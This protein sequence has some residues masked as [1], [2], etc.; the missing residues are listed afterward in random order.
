MQIGSI[1]FH[2]Q[3]HHHS[4]S[5]R[6]INFIHLIVFEEW[7]ISSNVKYISKTK[8]HFDFSF[9]RFLRSEYFHLKFFF[10]GIMQRNIEKSKIKFYCLTTLYLHLHTIVMIQ[11]KETSLKTM[12]RV[13]CVDVNSIFSL[14]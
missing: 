2:H 14:I 5:K 9:S 4:S 3:L 1:F 11:F 12:C 8:F 6:A 10:H 13:Y 7:A